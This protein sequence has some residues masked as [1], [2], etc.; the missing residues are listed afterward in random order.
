M[1]FDF[2]SEEMK[3]LY[4]GEPPIPTPDIL[5]D[6]IVRNY[7]LVVAAID[8]ARTINDVSRRDNSLNFEYMEGTRKKL[9]LFSQADYSMKLTGK[10]RVIIH[11]I[12][13]NKDCSIGH[14]TFEYISK[15]YAKSYSKTERWP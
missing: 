3:Q 14:V 4:T 12:W 11:I 7:V 5:T 6:D 10:W 9:G 13:T 8:S 1:E 2:R 15:H